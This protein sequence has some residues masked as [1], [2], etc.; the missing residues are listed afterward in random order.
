MRAVNRLVILAVFA[1]GILRADD[2]PDKFPKDGAWVRYETETVV[3]EPGGER[4]SSA[5]CTLS[6]VGS[7]VDDGVPCRWVEIKRVITDPPELARTVITKTL[8]PEKDLPGERLTRLEHVR[9]RWSRLG[10]K[11]VR[12]AETTGASH[13]SASLLL[14]TSGML[15]NSEP[16]A[17]EAKDIDLQ[18]GKLKNAEA[19][20]GEFIDNIRTRGAFA[21]KEYK[22]VMKYIVWQHPDLPIGFAE[23]RIVVARS[24]GP[25]KE[26]TEYRIQDFGSDAKSELPDNN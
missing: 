11:P 16:V 23:A 10:D 15:K 8:V 14:W 21:D 20:T 6:F 4:Q 2:A 7:V 3:S 26:T 12:E 13:Y 19:R 1:P 24:L 25:Q 5:K 22:S 9:R 18:R 17:K